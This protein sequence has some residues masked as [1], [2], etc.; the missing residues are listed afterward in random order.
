MMVAFVLNP[1]SAVAQKTT[2]GIDCSQ[3]AAKHLLQQD[4]QR[5]GLT[6]MECG[7]IPRAKGAGAGAEEDAPQLPP[8]V[9]VSNRSCSS[10]SSCTHSESMV[11]HSTVPNNNTVVVNYN[12]DYPGNGSN[13]SGTSY[14]TDNGATFTQMLP[15]PFAT[16]H[17]TNY[18]DPLMVYNSKLGLWFGGDL[19][20]ACGGFGVG[21]WSSPDGQNWT[22][23]SCAHNGDNDDRP[24]MWVDNNPYSAV[25]GRMYVSLN[26]FNIDGGALFVTHSDDGVTWSTAVQLSTSFIRD[27]QLTGA[28]PG[29]PPPNARYFSTVFSAAMDEGGGGLS[30]RQNVF[31]RSLDGGVTWTN[32]VTGP[33]FNAAGDGTC[34]SNSYFAYMHPIWRHMGWGEPGV[35]P[36]G[37]VHYVYA[38]QGSLSTGDIFYVRSADNGQTWSSPILLN[39]P[40][41]N[42]YQSH[43]MPSLSVNY[44]PTG[45][46]QPGNVTVSWYDRR[47][48]TTACNEVTDPGCSYYRYGIQSADNG[49]TWGPNVQISD[50]LIPQPAQDDPEIQPCYAGDYDYSTALGNTAYVTW[51]DGRVA[52]G[53]VQVQNEEF[54]AVPEP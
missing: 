37:V 26:N 24:S 21:L 28:I 31:Y 18:G 40:E 4:N 30:T 53:G 42:Q 32:T 3:I 12:D 17:G 14:S 46:T 6:L 33:R 2:T 13:Y 10:G 1:A 47:E 25:Y 9:L 38:G 29:P 27:V 11:W 49:V 39:T 43:W 8:N 44:N 22:A 36:G 34:P 16:G 7:V 35:G 15:P 54:D 51:T 48:A 5:A 45:F 23:A 19:A 41:T 20:T 52:V 50:Q